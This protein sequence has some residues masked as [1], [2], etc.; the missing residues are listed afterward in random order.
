MDD[1][2]IPVAVRGEDDRLQ[3]AVEFL[4]RTETYPDLLA[5][6]GDHGLRGIVIA[7]VSMVDESTRDR[8]RIRMAPGHA[9]FEQNTGI[10]LIDTDRAY[11]TGNNGRRLSIEEVIVHELVH[12]AL[13]HTTKEGVSEGPQGLI[14]RVFGVANFLDETTTVNYVDQSLRREL[15]L[16]R[17]LSYSSMP[18]RIH[19]SPFYLHEN[20][21]FERHLQP[22]PPRNQSPDPKAAPGMRR[23][24]NLLKPGDDVRRTTVLPSDTSETPS[25]PSSMTADARVDQ[26]L[27]EAV[28]PSRPT[29][30][31]P[32]QFQYRAADDRRAAAPRTPANS[33]PHKSSRAAMIE[34]H[35]LRA[36]ETA[37]RRVRPSTHNAMRRSRPQRRLRPGT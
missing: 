23:R 27:D 5:Q 21:R 28:R 37:G 10:I 8:Y 26:A 12:H 30:R 24:D 3:A 22:S 16:S 11:E 2:I 35:R 1:N 4:Q 34:Q 32:D 31:S 19:H 36:L 7:P 17:R 33:V 25:A 14:D 13:G 18:Y 15:N 6:A 20:P 9:F 29:V